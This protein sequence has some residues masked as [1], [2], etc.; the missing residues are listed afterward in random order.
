M[1]LFYRNI[2]FG[3]P[4]KSKVMLMFMLIA[5]WCYG[6]PAY[7]LRVLPYTA[8]FY[9]FECFF[10]VITWVTLNSL[11][12]YNSICLFY[13]P[14]KFTLILYLHFFSVSMWYC[15]WKIHT[16]DPGFL[17]KNSADY[18]QALKQV[19]HFFISFLCHPNPSY[20]TFNKVLSSGIAV[21]TASH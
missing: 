19:R 21:L 6:Y 15:F 7:I 18:D 9:R 10:A 17:P 20:L 12:F 5:S 2:L 8:D 16:M 14:I 3:P 4:G 1:I 11:F 13:V